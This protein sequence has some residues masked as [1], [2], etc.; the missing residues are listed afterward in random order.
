MSGLING[1]TS[2]RLK[3]IRERE[4]IPQENISYLKE[5]ITSG[6]PNNLE[7][8]AAYSW[9]DGKKLVGLDKENHSLFYD[10]TQNEWIVDDSKV[11]EENSYRKIRQTNAGIIIE[12]EDDSLYRKMGNNNKLLSKDV[13]A[14][15][16][17]PR[18]KNY[19]DRIHIIN[20]DYLQISIF[21]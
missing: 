10:F 21:D 8:I 7:N 3:K 6:I 19:Q 13:S 14:W 15:R 4:R 18:S 11:L 16:V 17:F 20:E 9:F 12:T 5:Y 2:D 1:T